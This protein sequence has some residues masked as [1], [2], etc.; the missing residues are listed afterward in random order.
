MGPAR[1]LSLLVVVSGLTLGCA[2]AA[3]CPARQAPVYSV[4]TVRAH[5]VHEPH[6]W[7][8]RTVLVRALV[9]GC[10]FPPYVRTYS[11]PPASLV[12]G[13]TA[14]DGGT[15]R[16]AWAGVDALRASLRRIAVLDRLIPAPQVLHW[17]VV[18][19]YRIQLRAVLCGHPGHQQAACDLHERTDKSGC[20]SCYQALLLDAAP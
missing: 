20:S 15:L 6:A 16:V 9:E 19:T 7:L 11:C 3:V 4:T 2:V 1:A 5:L 12:D 10:P 18:A 13:G 14:A 8:G 17:G